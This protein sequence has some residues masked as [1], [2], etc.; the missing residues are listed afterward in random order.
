MGRILCASCGKEHDLSELEP[1]FDRP[2][3]YFEVPADDRAARTLNT[4]GLCAIRGVGTEPNR[5][6]VRV[7][8]PVPVR[9]EARRFSWGIWTEVSE[10]DFA[11]VGDH[12]ND[13][14]RA[15]LPPFAGSLANEV[16]FMPDDAGPVL[17]LRGVGRFLGPR[18]YPE[19]VLDPASEH[20]FAVEQ[21]EGI[22]PERL[23]EYLSPVIHGAE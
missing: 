3:A 23:L 10:A 4:V 6:F 8:L 5:Y 11:R 15:S 7:V 22:Y 16:P 21:R 20:P 9:G 12:W 2:D 17:G 1:S 14:D 13:P 19:F 18:D